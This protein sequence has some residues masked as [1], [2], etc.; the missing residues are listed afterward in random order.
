MQQIK[1]ATFTKYVAKPVPKY[2]LDPNQEAN[3]KPGLKYIQYTRYGK[4]KQIRVA[5]RKLNKNHNLHIENLKF[6]R[7]VTTF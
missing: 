4:V 3:Y 6:L 5:E 1:A 2:K 7:N